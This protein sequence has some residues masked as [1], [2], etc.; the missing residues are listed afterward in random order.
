MAGRGHFCNIIGHDERDYYYKKNGGKP[1]TAVHGKGD[2]DILTFVN[3]TSV[4]RTITDVVYAQMLGIKL[5]SVGLI[6]ARGADIHFADNQALIERQG[7]LEMTA[8]RVGDTLYLLDIAV[9]R[10]GASPV[11]TVAHSDPITIQQWHLRLAHLSFRAII[12]MASTEAVNGLVLPPVS[13][14]P[15]ERCHDCAKGNMSRLPFY[16]STT[17]STHIGSLVHSDVCGPFQIPSF[18]DALCYV[19]F[20]DDFSGYRVVNFI[21][22]KSELADLTCSAL[23]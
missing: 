13:V 11:A 2:I 23:L 7:T 14:P 17:V 10:S 8:K 15:V 5:L 9:L 18:N 16:P 6:T 12:K 19:T 20:R 22:L 1:R 3:G 4:S 21:K